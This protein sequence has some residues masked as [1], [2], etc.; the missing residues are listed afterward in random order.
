MALAEARG[1]S[2]QGTEPL[3]RTSLDHYLDPLQALL[4]DDQVTE[5]C[6]NRPGELFI[7]RY[8]GW[9]REDAPFATFSWCM[10][11]AR[12]VA[13]HSRQRITAVQPLLS[14]TLPGGE[15]VQ[16]AMPP[17]TE[18]GKVS[19]TVRRPASV[20]WSLEDLAAKGMFEGVQVR[21]AGDRPTEA[22]LLSET[23]R[24]LQALLASGHVVQFLR[25][26]VRLRRN[27]LLSG[28]TGSGKTTV[29]KALILEVPPDERLVS[30]EDTPELSFRNQ[31]NHVRLFYSQGGQGLA[32]ISAGE[33]LAGV[34]RQRPDRVFVSEVRTGDEAY[35][36]LV[37]ISS[38]HPGSITSVHADTAEGA[39]VTL[40][41]LM[42]RSEACV[43]MS[44]RE[45]IELA[46]LS[47]DIV[48]QC[49][50]RGQRRAV[51]EIWHD[52]LVK[53]RGLA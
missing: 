21:L 26:A 11:I 13:N 38:G 3:P 5:V 1:D 53:R 19:I 35:H 8:D 16:I 32:A 9:H 18:P 45:G 31:P 52:P 43:G 40:A 30:I 14:A 12:L 34:K 44:T 46:Q 42:K 51:T 22:G 20:L 10:A 17:A 36:Y 15:R 28:A 37:S 25:R 48:V 41:Q 50:R 4:A 7:E 2:G 24:E 27:I 29:S 49:G 33:L 47:I 23:D 6:I 39:F